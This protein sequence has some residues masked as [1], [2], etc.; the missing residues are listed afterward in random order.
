[1]SFMKSA[2]LGLALALGVSSA[3]ADGTLDVIAAHKKLSVAVPQDF[4]PF[5]SVGATLEPEGYDIDV[6]NLIGKSLGVPVE[7][8]P[9]TSANRV[10]YLQTGKVDLIISSLGAN[11]DRAKV[12]SFSEAYAPFFSAVFASSKLSIAA[13]ADL[14]AKSLGVTRG[15]VEDLE[16]SKVAPE[17]AKIMRFEDNATTLTAF[18]SGQTDAVATSNAVAV[19]IAKENPALGIDMKFKVKDSPCYI[20]FKKDDTAL[21]DKLNAILEAAKAD[22]TLDKLSVKWFGAPTGALPGVPKF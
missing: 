21:Q 14:A 5:G 12:I 22:G 16:I 9:V 8:V 11:A 4:A 19:K 18:I 10:P 15:S 7:L 17:A 20:G 1:M 2:I 6:A 3:Y 13:P